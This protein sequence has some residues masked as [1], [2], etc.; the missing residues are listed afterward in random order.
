M[1]L[2]REFEV[3]GKPRKRILGTNPYK[4][5]KGCFILDASLTLKKSLALS[6]PHFPC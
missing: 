5:H 4:F 2:F 3:K 1:L 6:E